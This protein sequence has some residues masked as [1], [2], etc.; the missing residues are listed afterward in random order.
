MR[1]ESVWVLLLALPLAVMVAWLHRRSYAQLGPTARWLSV[2]LRTVL[3]AAALL[4][5]SRPVWRKA[6]SRSHA[7]FVVD[8]SRSVSPEN[9]DAALADVDRLAKDALKSGSQSRVS[10]IAFGRHAELI[11]RGVDKWEGFPPEQRERMRYQ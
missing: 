5:I 6:S 4:A 7:I 8:V 2:T 1:F 10:V 11:A 3:L 9:V